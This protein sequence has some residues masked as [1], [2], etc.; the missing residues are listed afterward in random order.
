M[1]TIIDNN[2]DTL[3]VLDKDQKLL[4]RSI[5]DYTLLKYKD[6]NGERIN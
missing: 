3:T 4:I 2:Y 6:F 1:T 5:N